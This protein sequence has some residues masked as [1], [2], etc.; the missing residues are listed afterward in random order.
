MPESNLSLEN[1]KR[2]NEYKLLLRDHDDK[3]RPKLASWAKK[4]AYLLDHGW[5]LVEVKHW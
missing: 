2:L 5:E 1:L 3:Y 4:L